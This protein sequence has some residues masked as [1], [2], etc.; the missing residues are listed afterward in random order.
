MI[1]GA[2]D[3]VKVLDLSQYI[4]GPY[5]SLQMQRLGA[6]VTKVERPGGD[7]MRQLGAEP[8]QVSAAY[9]HLNQH[10][11]TIELDLK[12]SGGANEFNVLL[13]Q[14]DVLIDG[15]RPGVLSRLGY[16]D[17]QLQQLNPRLV[18]CHLSGF[19]QHGDDARRAGHDLSYGARAGLYSRPDGNPGMPIFPPVA[20]HSGA[21]QALTMICAALYQREKSGTAAVLDISIYHSLRDWQY[22]FA[23]SSLTEQI[24]GAQACYNIY[25]CQDGL[26]VTLAALEAKFWQAFCIAVDRPDW[27]KRHGEPM[28]QKQLIDELSNLFQSRTQA[29][30]QLEL[31]AV[32]C[33]FEVIPAY[34]AIAEMVVSSRI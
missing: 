9:L 7:P 1:H 2:L 5:A 17:A 13:L 28:P 19:G 18:I 22:L 8:G 25:A 10:K 23:S 21:M 26:Y 6:E 11:R 15:F 12:S 34:A 16:S 24:S 4:P 20:D 32:D 14:S 33:C 31:Q 3:G 29:Q 27:V 30:W